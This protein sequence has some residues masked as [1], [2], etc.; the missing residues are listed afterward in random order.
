MAFF[1]SFFMLNSNNHSALVNEY[2][3]DCTME[4]SQS[5]YIDRT[6]RTILYTILI[7]L[8]MLKET[9]KHYCCPTCNSG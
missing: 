4:H 1:S 6:V 2:N 3:Q 8:C 5:V 9:L 7:I